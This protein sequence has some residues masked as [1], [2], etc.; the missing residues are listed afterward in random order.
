MGFT[1]EE[2]PVQRVT[3]DPSNTGSTFYYGADYGYDFSYTWNISGLGVGTHSIE[4]TAF[5]H[6]YSSRK[7]IRYLYIVAGE[8]SLNVSRVVRRADNYFQVE[9]YVYNDGIGNARI[10]RIEDNVEYF[11]PVSKIVTGSYEVK[12]VG[13]TP[14]SYSLVEIDFFTEAGGN[15][16][17]LAPGEHI[18]VEYLAVPLLYPGSVEYR[19]GTRELQV[20]LSDGSSET[21][22]R[23]CSRTADGST[24]SSAV[25]SAKAISDYL[26][27]T[28]VERLIAVFAPSGARQVLSAMAE[29]AQLK[30][31]ILGNLHG[32][33]DDTIKEWGRGMMGSDGVAGN[34]LS[35]G[36]LLLVGETEIVASYTL[37]ADLPRRVKHTD[38][39]YASTGDIWY[40]PDLIVGR[41]IGNSASDLIIPIQ[42]S[43]DVYKGKPGFEWN[44]SHAL[45]I[46]GSGDGVDEFENSADE[47]SD[48]LSTAGF[49]VTTLKKREIE[50]DGGDIT[51]EF[52]NHED[53]KDVIVFRDHGRPTV[54]TGVIG[55][56]GFSPPYSANFGNCKPFAFAVC[57]Y[58]GLYEDEDIIVA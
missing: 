55:I 36:Y 56:G 12:S 15:E 21:F 54:W 35:N 3:F 57:C 48:L 10:D 28:D 11:Q 7:T 29:L 51:A 42:T 13:A 27:V 43:I 18:A 39:P 4:V 24:L 14:G 20:Y 19:I 8:P 2:Q 31:G 23:P 34:Y 52:L 44:R 26:I 45:V 5:A 9:L 49:S 53:N 25:N 58:A 6:D 50:D 30:T 17:I 41:I 1:E 33:D 40:I 37:S 47:L 16:I 22:D 38:L 46:A 32:G